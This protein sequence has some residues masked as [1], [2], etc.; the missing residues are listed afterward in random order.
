MNQ[1]LE[2]LRL[3]SIFHYVVGGIMGLFGCF[4]IIHLVVGIAAL[5]GAM[6]GN[7]QGPPEAFGWL[8]ICAAVFTMGF[9][10]GIAIAILLAGNKLASHT[11]HTFCL[12]VAALECMFMP[13]GTVLGVLTIIV[14]LRP[15]VKELFGVASND[16]AAGDAGH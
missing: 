1:D 8:F 14:L 6:D 2:H 9:I 7:G 11:G 15:T 3:L 10:W 4:P 13:L 5:G 12:V 16:T